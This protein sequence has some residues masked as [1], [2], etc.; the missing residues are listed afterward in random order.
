MRLLRPTLPTS[1]NYDE[2]KN[3]KT[4][5]WIEFVL[6][7]SSVNPHLCYLDLSRYGY[8]LLTLTPYDALVEWRFVSDITHRTEEEFVGEKRVL[9]A[10][11]TNGMYVTKR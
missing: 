3:L 7:K 9:R 5:R 10:R 4:V 8:L 1:A 11:N 6:S 2:F